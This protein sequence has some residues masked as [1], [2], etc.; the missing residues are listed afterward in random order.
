MEHAKAVRESELFFRQW[1]RSP[2]SMG[3]IIPSSRALARSV[4]KEVAWQ[5]GWY[6]VELGGGTGAITSGLIEAGIPR[7]R[8]VVLE[9]DRALYEYLRERL[10]GVLVVQGDATRLDEILERLGVR[11]VSTVVSGLPMIGMPEAFKRAIVEQGFRA[12][13][14]QGHMLQYSY[15]P[16]CPVPAR[17]L[18]IRAR[19]V[20]TVPWNVP[21][22]YVWRYD[23]LDG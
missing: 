8:L 2:R 10:T 18:G 1:L 17:Q 7:E 5:P 13:A 14:G 3:S 9:L 6:V 20:R 21:P 19:I 4:A 23:R 11:E 16:I 12:L 15:S 22:A